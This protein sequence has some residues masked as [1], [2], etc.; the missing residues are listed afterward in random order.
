MNGK[1]RYSVLNGYGKNTLCLLKNWPIFSMG[2]KDCILTVF[3]KNSVYIFESQTWKNMCQFVQKILEII[4]K[5]SA[6][7]IVIF[8]FLIVNFVWQVFLTRLLCLSQLEAYI[9]LRRKIVRI[10]FSTQGALNLKT[11]YLLNSFRLS[12]VPN[13]PK[14]L[15]LPENFC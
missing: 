4:W 6:F 13:L 9:F 15:K 11:I 14:K 1:L 2:I 3:F 8:K 10:S 5:K 12:F 7:I